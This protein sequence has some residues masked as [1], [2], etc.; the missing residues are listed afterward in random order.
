[1]DMSNLITSVRSLST[2]RKKILAG[3]KRGEFKRSSFSLHTEQG[4]RDSNQDAVGWSRR[5]GLEVFV[6]ADGMGGDEGGEIAS[7]IAVLSI[8]KAFGKGTKILE[9]VDQADRAIA[10]KGFRV[11]KIDM[12]TTIAMLLINETQMNL[13]ILWAGDTRVK[14]IPEKGEGFLL[15]R[16]D[17][18]FW[19]KYEFLADKPLSPPISDTTA[20]LIE[21]AY[22]TAGESLSNELNE[23]IKEENERE[24]SSAEKQLNALSAVTN[25]LGASNWGQR[26]F[27]VSRSISRKY[28]LDASLKEIPIEEIKEDVSPVVF[29]LYS[30][31]LVHQMKERKVTAI[32]QILY[33]EPPEVI[34]RRLIESAL[35]S[36]SGDNITLAVAKLPYQ[37]QLSSLK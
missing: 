11:K 35:E 22:L 33:G 24:I 15:T 2:S 32:V 30:D 27:D 4:G 37:L 25:F 12:G 3:V 13:Q 1:M 36:G 14:V 20:D 8:L 19:E 9:A 17:R 28:P 34:G 7:K 23:A 5:K 21:L 26:L 10:E 29:L 6:V 31:G 18:A 16:D